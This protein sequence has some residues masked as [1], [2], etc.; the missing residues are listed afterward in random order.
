[1]CRCTTKPTNLRCAHSE[2]SDQPW[3]PSSLIRVFAMPFVGSYRSNFS[4][5][6]QRRLIGLGGSLG[7]SES[8]LGAYVSLSVLSCYGS[9]ITVPFHRN[10]VRVHV[11]SLWRP[12]TYNPFLFLICQVFLARINHQMP[13]EM[14]WIFSGFTVL[15]KLTSSSK[16]KYMLLKRTEHVSL[17]ESKVT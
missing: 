9:L 6:E 2:D 13:S 3:Q 1:M 12:H 8:S 14:E 4:S 10:L 15:L 16:P 11:K 7:W 17:T 5:F